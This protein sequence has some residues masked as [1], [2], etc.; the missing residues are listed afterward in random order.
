MG[1]PTL[2]AYDGGTRLR[3]LQ[4]GDAAKPVQVWSEVRRETLAAR[5]PLWAVLVGVWLVLAVGAARRQP[6]WVAAIL[7]LGFVVFAFQLSCYYYAFMLLFG[8]LWPRHRSIGIALCGLAAA[9]HWI[10]AR[11]ADEEEQYMRLS[12]LALLLVGYVTLVLRFAREARPPLPAP[13]A[14]A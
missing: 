9:S 4:L 6:D 11:F 3:L 2:L 8:L 1:L 14:L 12:L 10:G 13:Q 7:G 5:A